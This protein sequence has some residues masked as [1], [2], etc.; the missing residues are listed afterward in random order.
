MV[1]FPKAINGFNAIPIKIPILFLKKWKKNYQIC[2]ESQKTQRAKAILREKNEV[3]GITVLSSNYRAMIIKAAS[4]WQK[5][6]QIQRPK[7]HN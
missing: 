6:K 7:G 4:H 3:G 2:V 5:K 1:M